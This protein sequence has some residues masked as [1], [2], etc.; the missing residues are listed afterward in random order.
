MKTFARSSID[1]LERFYRTNL[2]NSLT[3]FKSVALLGTVSEEGKENLAIFSQ[4]I[5]VG[6]N[7]PQ[8]GVLFR[9]PTVERHT[10]ENIQATQAFTI[11]HI[12]PDF[13]RAA[14]H[15]AARWEG[16]EFAACELTPAYHDNFPAPFVQESLVRL[17]LK[18]VEEHTLGNGT[19]LVVGEIN[20]ISLL[21]DC[22]GEDGFVD[23]EAAKTVTCSG[24]DAY[25]TTEKIVRLSYAKPNEPLQEL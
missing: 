25:H 4:L 11:N 15:T 10:L 18:F 17:G 5:H 2:I 19:V 1:E 23:L 7:P 21:E 14:H 3:G 22:L 9:P 13:V 16:S 8:V 12:R 6:A 20:Q 24:L